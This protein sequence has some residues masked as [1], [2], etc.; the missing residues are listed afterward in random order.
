MASESGRTFGFLFESY[1][2][3][4]DAVCKIVAY[5]GIKGEQKLY[6]LT[7]LG[8]ILFSFISELSIGGV[9]LTYNCH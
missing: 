2:N 8:P 7:I 3:S 6:K 5:Q 4:R 1:A 9:P